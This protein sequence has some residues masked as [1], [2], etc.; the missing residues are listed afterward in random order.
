MSWQIC[1]PA[2][3]NWQ[4]VI[5]IDD[6]LFL[7]L[8]RIIRL[9]KDTTRVLICI[10][11]GNLPVSPRAMQVGVDIFRDKLYLRYFKCNFAIRLMFSKPHTSQP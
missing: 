3:F 5:I 9:Q 8:V 10:E 4:T 6:S 2:N 1:V 7:L 11:T